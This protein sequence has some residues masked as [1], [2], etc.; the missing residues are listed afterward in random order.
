M[1]RSLYK[2]AGERHNGLGTPAVLGGLDTR[3][4]DIRR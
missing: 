2:G 1:G 4:V 3:S